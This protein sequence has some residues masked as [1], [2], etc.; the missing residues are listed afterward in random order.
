[1]MD[2]E[3]TIIKKARNSYRE[4]SK[5]KKARWIEKLLSI[6]RAYR[7]FLDGSSSCREANEIVSQ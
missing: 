2:K 5:A 6:Y 7:N 4:V 1:M 3:V